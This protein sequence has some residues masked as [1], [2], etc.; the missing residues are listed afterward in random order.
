MHS[1]GWKELTQLC[2]TAP[3]NFQRLGLQFEKETRE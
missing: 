1:D 2:C 3:Y